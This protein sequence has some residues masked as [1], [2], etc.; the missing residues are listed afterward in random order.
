MTPLNVE[1][2]WYNIKSALDFKNEKDNFKSFYDAISPRKD[3][4]TST[5]EKETIN[6]NRITENCGNEVKHNSRYVFKSINHSKKLF[7]H[8]L[9][10]LIISGQNKIKSKLLFLLHQP[11]KPR[12]ALNKCQNLNVL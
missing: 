4:S 10:P 5:V 9:S 2:S 3:I 12:L 6:V 1:L 8:E 7:L 11:K